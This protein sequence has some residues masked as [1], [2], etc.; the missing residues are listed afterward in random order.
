[1][2][3]RPAELRDRIAALFRNPPHETPLR[4]ATPGEIADAVLA[5]LPVPADRGAVLREA[6]DEAASAMRLFPDTEECAVAL[7]ALEGLADRL[8]RMAAQ[9]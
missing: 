9:S 2:T 6:A 3:N 7:G 5:V 1:M 8:R 4:D